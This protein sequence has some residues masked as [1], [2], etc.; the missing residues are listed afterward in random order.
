M[1]VENGEQSFFPG[2]ATSDKQELRCS[3]PNTLIS[4]C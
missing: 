3:V 2:C 1:V 4:K